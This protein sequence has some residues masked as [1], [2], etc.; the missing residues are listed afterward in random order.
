M[1]SPAK[2][3]TQSREESCDRKQHSAKCSHSTHTFASDA[4][5]AVAVGAVGGAGYGFGFA[6][7]A[8]L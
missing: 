5:V 7:D 3:E 2:H 4:A 6:A 8:V 1:Q